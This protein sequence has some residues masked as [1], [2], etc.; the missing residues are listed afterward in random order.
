MRILYLEVLMQLL[1]GNRK[2]DN[3]APSPQPKAGVGAPSSIFVL[4]KPSHTLP[5]PCRQPEVWGGKR[6]R[7]ESLPR[8]MYSSSRTTKFALVTES[9]KS[10]A[11][12][13]LETG[14]R[15]LPAPPNTLPSHP[16]AS[17]SDLPIIFP[18]SSGRGNTYRILEFLI[19]FTIIS[20][21]PPFFFC[22]R[23]R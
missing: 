22:N 21:C 23:T 13:Q 9:L 8:T 5:T 3:E 12:Q 6:T 4:P 14:Q 16:P 15:R 17:V 10:S 19:V 1:Y 7:E 18:S 11:Q 2:G 20:P